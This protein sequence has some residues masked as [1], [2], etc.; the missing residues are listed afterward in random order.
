MGATAHFRQ[1]WM[2]AGAGMTI[3]SS[4]AFLTYLSEK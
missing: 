3:F 2:P 4:P 1:S